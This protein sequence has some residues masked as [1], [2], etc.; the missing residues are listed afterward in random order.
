MAFTPNYIVL[1][2]V[3]RLLC[4]VIGMHVAASY[5]WHSRDPYPPTA[6]MLAKVQVLLQLMAV[7]TYTVMSHKA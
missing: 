7:L 4:Q 5:L 3:G 1:E 2:R 6:T